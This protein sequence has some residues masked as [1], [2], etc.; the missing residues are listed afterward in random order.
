[1]GISYTNIYECP[2]CLNHLSV[3]FDFTVFSETMPET[4][5]C[6]KCN[7]ISSLNNIKTIA[8][9]VSSWD[10]VCENADIPEIISVR[11]IL[12]E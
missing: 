8:T 5:K 12:E 10:E 7:T 4:I 11:Q 9:E 1:M 3:D 6:K 2:K